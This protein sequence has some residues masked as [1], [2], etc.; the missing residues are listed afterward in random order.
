MTQKLWQFGGFAHIYKTPTKDQFPTN[1]SGTLIREQSSSAKHHLLIHL[2]DPPPSY[3]PIPSH[4]TS[5]SSRAQYRA[6]LAL[7][8]HSR[9]RRPDQPSTRDLPPIIYIRTPSATLL[10][11]VRA[12]NAAHV[13][14]IYTVAAAIRKKPRQS[15][16]IRARERNL[17]PRLTR[18]YARLPDKLF[19]ARWRTRARFFDCWTVD[20]RTQRWK[21]FG[22]A[23]RAVLSCERGKKC[24]GN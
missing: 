11:I 5:N 9:A 10:F 13:H 12:L 17:Q 4:T 19:L 1:S 24:A 8:R 6:T 18:H 23:V 7:S 21:F 15:R 2:S 14:Y 3:H 20:A 22:W 16:V